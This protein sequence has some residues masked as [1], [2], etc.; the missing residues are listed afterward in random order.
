[1][2]DPIIYAIP[3]FVLLLVVEAV[4]FKVAQREDLRGYDAKDTRTS[5]SMGLGNV[6]INTGWKAVVLVIFAGLYELTP[7]RVPEAAVW[8]WVLLFFLDD[9]AYYWFHRISHEV[10]V[11]WASHVVHH[12][13]QYFNL[14]TALRQTWTPMTYFPFWAPIALLGYPPWMIFTMQ[15]VSLMYQFWIH[16][17]RIGRLPKPI[18]SIFNTPSHH[19]V[20]HGSND[21]YLDRNY[22][23]IL[24]VWDRMFGTFQG[25]EEP[26]RYGLTTNIRT[27]SPPT[28]AFHE[29]QAVWRDVR[30]ARNWRERF[31]YAFGGPAWKPGGAGERGLLGA[32]HADDRELVGSTIGGDRG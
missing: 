23:G 19:R 9:F 21:I 10:R 25:E 5:L 30:E 17:E 1:V 4:S 13:S 31:G 27:F 15:A 6:V 20:H 3:A 29:W 11:F 24:I 7:L 18:E 16:T 2:T 12:S 8:A 32:P 14:S 26:V 28:V 22:A